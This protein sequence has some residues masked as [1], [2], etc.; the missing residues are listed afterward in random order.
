MAQRSG[1]EGE[2]EEGGVFL[3]RYDGPGGWGAGDDEGWEGAGAAGGG[4]AVPTRQSP[5]SPDT[6]K[7]FVEELAAHVRTRIMVRHCAAAGL[8]ARRLDGC[9]EDTSTR[10]CWDCA[11]RC[12]WG[13]A[14]S[15]CTFSVP[16]WRRYGWRGA[17]AC[18]K[19]TKEFTDRSLRTLSNIDVAASYCDVPTVLVYLFHIRRSVMPR[20]PYTILTSI[21]TTVV[22]CLYA[23]PCPPSPRLTRRTPPAPAGCPR[24]LA[25][26]RGP[27]P[28]WG[29][30]SSRTMQLSYTPRAWGPCV[31][32]SRRQVGG[33]GG[34]P[35][36]LGGLQHPVGTIGLV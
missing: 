18:R 22:P 25:T 12:L 6:V 1:G 2:G 3:G 27:W 17:P 13:H 14:R 33:T 26:P 4:G 7:W 34:A 32:Q 35:E 30:W 31:R 21:I 19:D 10:R 9:R 28:A 11:L 23:G 8:A 24:L 29:T 5:P 36:Q 16:A 20:A 15:I